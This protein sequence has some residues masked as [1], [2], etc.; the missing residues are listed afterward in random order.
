MSD[1]DKIR[2]LGRL[3]DCN[4]PPTLML[5]DDVI[6]QD[7]IETNSVRL[8]GGSLVFHPLDAGR[9]WRK[10]RSFCA[11]KNHRP[12]GEGLEDG[13]NAMQL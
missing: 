5:M 1:G 11:E 8:V 3:R 9:F 7:R 10:R 13:F 6:A 4:L 2:M 12:P